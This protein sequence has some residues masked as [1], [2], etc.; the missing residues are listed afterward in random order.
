[1]DKWIGII[2]TLLGVIIGGGTTLAVTIYRA[3][4]E[5]NLERSKRSIDKLEKAHELLTDVLQNYKESWAIDLTY[6]STWHQ[7]E[8][9]KSN[10]KL[11]WDELKMLIGFYA[12]DFIEQL[13]RMILYCQDEYGPLIIQCMNKDQLPIAERKALQ[14]KLVSTHNGIV[15][16]IE[17]LQRAIITTAKIC[18]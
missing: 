16:K 18:M 7:L 10:E 9:S 14:S 13:N 5:R 17:S 2:G 15:E 11:P 6:V 1:M 3:R 4:H 12:P 8:R